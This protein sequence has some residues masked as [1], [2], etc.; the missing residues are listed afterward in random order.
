M[1]IMSKDDTEK[2]H[3]IEFD[4]DWLKKTT[5]VCILIQIFIIGFKIGSFWAN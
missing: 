3:L 5:F 4:S 2:Y 1:E